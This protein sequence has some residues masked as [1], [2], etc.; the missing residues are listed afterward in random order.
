MNET[1]ASHDMLEWCRVCGSNDQYSNLFYN[2]NRIL[3]QNLKS[4]LQVEVR[5]HSKYTSEMF[6]NNFQFKLSDHHGSKYI[7]RN[8]VEQV[9]SFIKFRQKYHE[10]SSKILSLAKVLDEQQGKE[11]SEDSFEVEALDESLEKDNL[12]C[13]FEEVMVDEKLG[14]KITP[15]KKDQQQSKSF[16]CLTCFKTYH[17]ANS[18]ARH[19]KTSHEFVRH[20]CEFCS[21]EFTQKSSLT[22][23]VRNLHKSEIHKRT[24]CTRAFQTEKV[25][26]Q[27]A[28]SHDVKKLD[29][30]KPKKGDEKKY[31]KQCQICGLF[32]K[33]IEEHKL[34]HRSKNSYVSRCDM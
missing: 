11:S 24:L 31:R 29:E 25:L 9:E 32:F 30:I 10:T 28:K 16:Q 33:H 17:H 22:E 23:H 19:I 27:H 6:V 8:C 2:I 20:L 34:T 26:M 15:S 4:L 13:S 18:L 12:S 7:C 21:S 3:L 14:E 1:V 5:R